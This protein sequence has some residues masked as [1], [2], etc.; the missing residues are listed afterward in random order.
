LPDF[1]RAVQVSFPHVTG[2]GKPRRGY[3]SGA[4]KWGLARDEFRDNDHFPY[5]FYIR[6]AR[7]IEGEYI[8]TEQD[9]YMASGSVRT[10]LKNDAIAIGDY[11][12][13][14]HG[15]SHPGELYQ[16]LTE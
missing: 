15:V 11:A 7:R 13:N 3:G 10:V 14:C 4:Q 9:T 5:R 1:S 16:D 6:E 12:L 2:V 8:F